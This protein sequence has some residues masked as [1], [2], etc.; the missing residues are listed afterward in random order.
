MNSL[1]FLFLLIKITFVWSYT[2]GDDCYTCINNVVST[3]KFCLP[4]EDST[5]G[6]CCDLSDSSDFCTQPNRYLCT[7]LA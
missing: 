7:D 2:I 1:T 5:F 6:Y 3:K 4:N